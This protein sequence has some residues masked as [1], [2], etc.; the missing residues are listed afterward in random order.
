MKKLTWLILILLGFLS[1]RADDF[2]LGEHGIL[3]MPVTDAW[4]AQNHDVQSGYTISLESKTGA[5]AACRITVIAVQNATFPDKAK[6]RAEFMQL[7]QSFSPGSVEKKP[8]PKEFSLKSG[9]GL[10]C[11]FTDASLVGKPP[12]KGNYKTVSPGL[13]YM[14]KDLVLAVTIFTDDPSGPE[15]RQL[16]DIIQSTQ[17]LTR[18]PAAK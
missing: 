9:F 7:A 18:A 13:I 4:V 6:T 16:V 5:N 10:Y 8:A 17:L 2:I 12:I 14:S 3:S 11:S 15:F 1:A